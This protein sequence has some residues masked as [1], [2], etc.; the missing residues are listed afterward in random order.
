MS[1]LPPIPHDSHGQ[2][3]E[4]RQS[5]TRVRAPITRAL[6]AG[7]D[8]TRQI[9]KGVEGDGYPKIVAPPNEQ[10]GVERPASSYHADLDQHLHGTHSANE[11]Y[12][13]RKA[14][15][16]AV[17]ATAAANDQPARR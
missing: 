6:I 1:Y 12:R 15:D 13:V 16:A 10:P 3:R 14:E 4:Y 17:V 5:A 8:L 2:G 11:R 9:H 7:E